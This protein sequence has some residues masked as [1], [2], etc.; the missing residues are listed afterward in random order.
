MTSLCMDCYLRGLW[1]CRYPKGL[2]PGVVSCANG[3][4]IVTGPP[5]VSSGVPM[6]SAVL[7]EVLFVVC[8]P[9]WGWVLRQSLVPYSVL[10][11]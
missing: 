1:S 10:R 4:R 3:R 11:Y 5:S 6:S 8:R 2:G 7:Q 9:P